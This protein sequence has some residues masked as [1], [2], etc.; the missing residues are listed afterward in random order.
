M[1]HWSPLFTGNTEA[2]WPGT[3]PWQ[4]VPESGAGAFRCNGYVQYNRDFGEKNDVM[5]CLMF[6]NLLKKKK[7]KLICCKCILKT[8]GEEIKKT[9]ENRTT[10]SD[11]SVLNM[12]VI[13]DMLFILS[14]FSEK[15]ENLHNSVG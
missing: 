11:C 7:E 2:V 15:R 10:K 4:R 3:L 14:E 5:A 13:L 6:E 12:G 9:K 1:E 8:L